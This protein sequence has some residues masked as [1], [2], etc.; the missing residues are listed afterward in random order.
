[1]PQ[2]QPI[3]KA[4]KQTPVE[5][6]VVEEQ[7]T[8]TI[9]LKGDDIEVVY[10]YAHLTDLSDSPLLLVDKNDEDVRKSMKGHWHFAWFTERE[11]DKWEMYGY[12]KV[13]EVFGDDVRAPV[14]TK[15]KREDAGC[16]VYLKGDDAMYAYCLSAKN[17]QAYNDHIQKSR[18][19]DPDNMGVA[20]ED[21]FRE[22]GGEF[23]GAAVGGSVKEAD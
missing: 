19:I 22:H 2:S 23:S 16:I 4:P 21:V 12:R 15:K 8:D 7:P 10:D 20:S 9:E 5:E 1:M 17:Y 14:Q 11:S 18:V 13:H 3:K 6:P